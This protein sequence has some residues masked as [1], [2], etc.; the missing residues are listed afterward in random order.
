VLYDEDGTR[1]ASWTSSTWGAT[2]ESSG[3]FISSYGIHGNKLYVQ[4]VNG[5]FEIL[6]GELLDTVE[7]SVNIGVSG[8]V[9]SAIPGDFYRFT[10]M[11]SGADGSLLATGTLTSGRSFVNVFVPPGK[12]PIFF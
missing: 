1:L 8:T 2:A 4:H 5:Y 10:T 3:S 11:R 9:K 12:S 7:L 6:S